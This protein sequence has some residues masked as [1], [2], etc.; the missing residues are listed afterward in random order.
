MFI[1]LEQEMLDHKNRGKSI[2]KGEMY[3]KNP[4]ID[5]DFIAVK[6]YLLRFELEKPYDEPSIFLSLINPNDE[7]FTL[8][9]S[10]GGKCWRCITM[11]TIDRLIEERSNNL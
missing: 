1:H 11:A 7:S 6:Y 5:T 9:S 8:A 2:F 3:V 4:G 10:R